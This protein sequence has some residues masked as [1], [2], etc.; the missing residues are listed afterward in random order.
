[1][2]R[3]HLTGKTG[4]YA[5]LIVAAAFTVLNA[6][7][8][9]HIDDPFI[10]EIA[11]RIVGHPLD[12]YGFDIFWLQWPQPVHEELTPPVV[13]YFWA[14]VLAVG[15]EAPVL[16]KLGFFPFAALLALSLHGLYRRYAPGLALPLSAGTLFSPAFLPG[17]NLMQDSPAQALGL[18]ALNLYLRGFERRSTATVLGAGVVA[19]LATQTK[20][21]AIAILAATLI[22][23]LLQ[24]RLRPA[25]L[26][27]A[28][29]L[30]IF[31][32]WELWMHRTYG[33]S[34]FLGQV[35][36][37]M[38]WVRRPEMVWPMLTLLGGTGPGLILLGVAATV[39]SRRVLGAAAAALLGGLA[40]LALA[41]L[42]RSVFTGMGLALLS[43]LA[44]AVVGS[45]R[46]FAGSRRVAARGAS[47][48]PAAALAALM[49]CLTTRRADAFLVA[50]LLVEVVLYFATSPFP[51]VRRVLG[52]LVVCGLILG[53]RAA[54]IGRL[55]KRRIP[56]AAVAL[57]TALC[58]LG[59]YVV[60]LRDAQAQR[61]GAESAAAVV[62]QQAPDAR[63][64]YVGHWGFQ[65]YAERSGMRPV[66]PDASRLAAGDWLVVPTNVDRQEITVDPGDTVL[67]RTLSVV[68]FPGLATGQGYYGGS[69]PLNHLPGERLRV[70]IHRVTRAVVPRTAWPTARIADW[71]L[72]AGG[73]T[74]AA[75]VPALA[76]RL[77]RDPVDG[78]RR[79]ALALAHLGAR[80]SPALDALTRALGDTDVAVRYWSVVA[81]GR[82]GP[83]AA[84][85]LP[86]I[87]ALADDPSQE[88]REAVQQAL[89][90]IRA[91]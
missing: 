34:M 77:L 50:W 66:V 23:G 27:S 44:L 5:L 51:A 20:Y 47:F 82:V 37:G 12:P 59:Y 2:N 35:R 30:T 41:P 48:A 90:S 61:A 55:R 84:G 36:H 29:A 11:Q 18:S 24:R 33:Q 80:S 67:D 85:A 46:P 81:L 6:L 22:H 14:L 49:R 28:V 64:W 39:R 13:P 68:G 88:I 25:L 52:I 7:K 87:T 91:P 71:A 54:L 86:R 62:R 63:V 57:F 69:S 32:G 38:F 56:A 75:A 26:L 19:G 70:E 89:D 45:F 3:L 15:G 4:W 10:Y 9:L 60:D 74:A 76:R 78:R 42:E 40:L 83:A 1:M 17:F 21:T 16:W 53:R 58:G 31:A 65:F 43:V 72:R 8:P 73:R 79:S